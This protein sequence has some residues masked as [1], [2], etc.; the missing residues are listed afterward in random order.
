VRQNVLKLTH[1]HLGFQKFPGVIPTDSRW[2]GGGKGKGRRKRRGRE[3]RGGGEA[4][5]GGEGD[6]LLQLG[7]DRRP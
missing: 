5:T 1:G 3:T 2:R 7:G 6:C 4:G